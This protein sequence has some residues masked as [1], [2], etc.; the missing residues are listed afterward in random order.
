MT[1]QEALMHDN[2]HH[3]QGKYASLTY[4][5][6]KWAVHTRLIEDKE[7][8]GESFEEAWKLFVEYNTKERT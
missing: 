5:K 6:G 7:Y 1:I 4:Y 2:I 3:V 8:D